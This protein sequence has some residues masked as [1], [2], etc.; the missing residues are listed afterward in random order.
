MAEFESP[1][2]ALDWSP[3]NCSRLESLKE[4]V[5]ADV[6]VYPVENP[7]LPSIPAK[8]LLNGSKVYVVVTTAAGVQSH[9]WTY[10]FI[11]DKLKMEREK[12]GDVGR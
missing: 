11:T 9:E 6:L 1:A 7:Q 4:G 2:Y 12:R 8:A 5:E 3:S 10:E